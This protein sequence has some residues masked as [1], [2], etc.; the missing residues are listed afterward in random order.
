MS[1]PPFLYK[2]QSVTEYSLKSLVERTVWMSS[3]A[4]FN[5]PFDCAINLD[6][7]KLE[8]SVAHAVSLLTKNDGDLV[9]ECTNLATPENEVAYAVLRTSLAAQMATIGVLCLTESPSEILMWSHYAQYHKGFCIEYR[10]DEGSLLESMARPVRYT[11]IYPSLSLKN[12]PVDADE[13]F[14]DICVHTKASQ[15][16]YEREWRVMAPV[17]AKL[18]R[19]PAPASAIIFGARMPDED[20]RVIYELLSPKSSIEFREAHL[21]EDVFGIGFRPYNP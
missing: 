1:I 10:V 16:S 9:D 8:E 20:K 7:K 4:S 18:Y 15:W 14:I 17:G 6:R 19:A 21:L 11:E 12:L 2:Y 3:P 5:D 13:N